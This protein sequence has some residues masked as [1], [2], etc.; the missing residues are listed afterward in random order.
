MNPA[1]RLDAQAISRA[2]EVRGVSRLRVFGSVL[3]DTFDREISDV[4]FLVDF[5]PGRGGLFRDYFD[6]KEDLERIVGA[7]VDLVEA[8]AVRNPYFARS[9]FRRAEDIY[10]A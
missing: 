2:C 8:G 9:V 6:L 5:L 3:G 1:E 7:N 4:D 10:A